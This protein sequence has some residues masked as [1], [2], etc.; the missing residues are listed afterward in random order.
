MKVLGVVQ[1]TGFDKR[2]QIAGVRPLFDVTK[3][4]WVAIDAQEEFPSNGEV[5][6]PNAV[7]AME[8][9]LVTFRA[10]PNAGEKHQFRVGDP[11]PEIAVIDL[12]RFGDPTTAR[13]ALVGGMVQVPGPVG[14]LPALIV[15]A[16]DI[17]V[18]PVELTRV[19]T[20]TVRLSGTNFAKVAS[21]SG[22]TLRPIAV[23]AKE[24]RLLRVD[25][26]SPTGYVD[27]DDD[28]TVVRRA[29]E[30]AV[31]VAKK[32]GTDT[33]QTKRQIEEASNAL[34]AQGGGIESQLER[35]RVER[36]LVVCRS[37]GAA[38]ATAAPDLVALLRE[39]PAV[40]GQ[41]EEV[42]SKVRA[43][44]ELTAR[45]EI[46]QELD[47]ELFELNEVKSEHERTK[48][49]IAAAAAELKRL[50][51][52]AADVRMKTATAA[53]DIEVAI[54]ERILTAIDK[55]FDLLAQVSVLR[56]F[57]SARATV[58]GALDT[59][60]QDAPSTI[61]WS[62]A[63]G[64]SINEKVAL[65]RALTDAARARGVD[66]QVMTQVH[67]AVAAGLLPVSLGPS[68]LAMMAAYAQAVCGGRV[69]ILHVSPGVLHPR[70]LAE[71][72]GGMA[73][74]TSASKDIDGLSLLVFEGANRAPIEASLLPLLQLGGLAPSAT[75][76]TLRLAAT[77]VLGATTVPVTPQL[78]SYAVAIYPGPQSPTL[79][80][81]EV[82][83]EV[84]SSSD[85]LALGDVP[86][87][88]VDTL[89]EEWPECSE[90]K[91]TLEKFGAA[92]SR[93]YDAERIAESLLQGLVLPYLVTALSA[94][95]QE[96]VLA[97]VNGDENA[98]VLRRLRRG[99][100]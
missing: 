24:Q 11:R 8:G 2:G 66:P 62:R 31:R 7:K 96:Q 55:P 10:E 30:I 78:W 19:A 49:A 83:K 5:F 35:Y 47:R 13:A 33:G 64:E 3:P 26:R 90:L 34:V 92:L 46:E 52:E 21:Y 38:V 25:E 37:S 15:C 73:D 88:Q 89:I 9:G 4:E 60:R 82:P 36:A 42:K 20:G 16:D 63:R 69:S 79:V 40:Q 6:W 80:G 29:L 91:P 84:G 76:P 94:D 100:C 87:E 59:P 56:P 58:Q 99:L 45:A 77:L 1:W 93:L 32:S 12:R 51:D 57:L 43:E 85:L 28:A 53:R 81:S 14:Q 95:E 17:L 61:D 75:K 54:D 41:L 70:E 23:S 65:R 98:K 27:W 68:A 18:G 48:S 72:P 22:F 86:R 74:A 44:A 50:N 67:A 39:H 71:V 97:R